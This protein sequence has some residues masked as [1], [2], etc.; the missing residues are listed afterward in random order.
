M[1]TMD[2]LKN[3]SSNLCNL[4]FAQSLI[5]ETQ[6]LF[7][8]SKRQLCLIILQKYIRTVV[9]K[10]TVTPLLSYVTSYFFEVTSYIFVT[11]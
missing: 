5:S 2:F 11:F 4:H 7:R 8:I 9:G 3:Y 6:L 1:R 10:V